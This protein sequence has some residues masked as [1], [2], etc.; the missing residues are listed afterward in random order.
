MKTSLEMRKLPKLAT[1]L[2]VGAALVFVIVS[3][4]WIMLKAA[5]DRDTVYACIVQQGPSAGVY[6]FCKAQMRM[7]R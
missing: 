7:A 5:K 1:V 2:F 6:D 4:G 3:S